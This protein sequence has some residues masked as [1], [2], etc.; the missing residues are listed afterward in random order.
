MTNAYINPNPRTLEDHRANWRILY[1]KGV[2]IG[3]GLLFDQQTRTIYVQN[4]GGGGSPQELIDARTGVASWIPA[5]FTPTTYANLDARLDQ[6]DSD[7]AFYRFGLFGNVAGSSLLISIN[8]AAFTS[9]AYVVAAMQEASTTQAG[10]TWVSKRFVATN[11]GW[12]NF[13]SQLNTNQLGT[14]NYNGTTREM[15]RTTG[16][17]GQ[18]WW[19]AVP[20]GFTGSQTGW[21]SAL[22]Q[23]VGM[24]CWVVSHMIED[25]RTKRV[26]V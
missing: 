15:R 11:D 16:V 2:P 3:N 10:Q 12:Q 9:P 1:E 8:G 18:D 6:M 26:F 19:Q 4:T 22:A 20:T 24:V 14:T 5:T 23:Q 7:M 17:L 25:L 21:L 13:W